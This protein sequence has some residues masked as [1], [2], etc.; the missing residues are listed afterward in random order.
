MGGCTALHP[1][2]RPIPVA[3]GEG[4]LGPHTLT[5]PDVVQAVAARSH[6]S[7]EAV[8]GSHHPGSGAAHPGCAQAGPIALLRPQSCALGLVRC[9][10]LAQP[11]PLPPIGF[12]VSPADAVQF[13]SSAVRKMPGLPKGHLP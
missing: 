2:Q 8:R 7:H 6:A 13:G 9:R 4:A 1:V 10:A 11:R 3:A 12:A 5:L